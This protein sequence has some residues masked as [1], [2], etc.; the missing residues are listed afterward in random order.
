MEIMQLCNVLS[1]TI[2][3]DASQRHA[4]EETLKQVQHGVARQFPCMLYRLDQALPLA[5]DYPPA[6]IHPSAMQQLAVSNGMTSALAHRL[7]L[8]HAPLDGA[9]GAI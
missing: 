7:A 5:A 2:S 1:A 4:A 8:P 9:P 6:N 3:Q